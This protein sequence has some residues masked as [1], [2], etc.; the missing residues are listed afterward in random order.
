MIHLSWAGVI[1]LSQTKG[2]L[3]KDRL[4]LCEEWLIGGTFAKLW[5]RDSPQDLPPGTVPPIYLLELISGL[6]PLISA[7]ECGKSSWWGLQLMKQVQWS[8][9]DAASHHLQLPAPGSGGQ[10]PCQRSMMKWSVRFWVKQL[11]ESEFLELFYW[12]F[13]SALETKWISGEIIIG[14]RL[15]KSSATFSSYKCSSSELPSWQVSIWLWWHVPGGARL[16]GPGPS[17]L[18]GTDF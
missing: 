9:S 18:D 15:S 8:L 2:P 10:L 13:C 1:S 14:S 12:A 6:N 7:S 3:W 16:L 4:G 17:L 11:S 5:T